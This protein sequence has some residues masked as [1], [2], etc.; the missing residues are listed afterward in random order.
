MILRLGDELNFSVA[1]LKR[2]EA[3]QQI[4]E[5]CYH[6]KMFWST[7]IEDKIEVNDTLIKENPDKQFNLLGGE[8]G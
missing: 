4:T 2:Q 5:K 6:I 8:L 1:K 7:V 3:K